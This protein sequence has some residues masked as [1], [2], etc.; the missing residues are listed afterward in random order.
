[1][2]SDCLTIKK[3]WLSNC[4]W[5]FQILCYFMLLLGLDHIW[6]TAWFPNR[7]K[8]QILHL[9]LQWINF[10]INKNLYFMA[11]QP[12]T[13]WIMT[14]VFLVSHI[15]LL[16]HLPEGSWSKLKNMKNSENVTTS[17]WSYCTWYFALTS[18]NN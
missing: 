7:T 2:S 4:Q 18:A 10:S 13:L 1:M 5:E 12:G 3:I 14:D 17:F 8:N 9:A 16:F 11:Q 15:L 6:K